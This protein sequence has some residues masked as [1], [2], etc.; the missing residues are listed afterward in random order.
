MC[1]LGVLQLAGRGEGRGEAGQPTRCGGSEEGGQPG[2]PTASGACC[3]GSRRCRQTC[4][5]QTSG[6]AG[7]R[8]ARALSARGSGRRRR[9]AGRPRTRT[10]G[11]GLPGVGG[12]GVGRGREGAR[13][14]AGVLGCRGRVRRG[15]PSCRAGEARP[16][17][18]ARG[19]ESQP[20]SV[21]DG[22]EGQVEGASGAGPSLALQD[23]IESWVPAWARP[24]CASP[25]SL[26]SRSLSLPLSSPPASLSL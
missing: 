22:G 7:L 11:W 20:T 2:G 25:S 18:R 14:T 12:V 1:E 16:G 4:W 5:P 24:S 23:A 26:P 10:K 6:R 21:V 3:G 19:S 15:L 13:R 9:G 17:A 8:R